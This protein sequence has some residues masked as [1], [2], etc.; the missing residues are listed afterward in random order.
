MD[1]AYPRCPVH[2][3]TDEPCTIH[4]ERTRRAFQQAARDLEQY[5]GGL[6]GRSS[7]QPVRLCR[8]GQHVME[9]ENLR[10]RSNGSREC[11]ACRRANQRKGHR[12]RADLGYHWISCS[13]HGCS[14]GLWRFGDEPY[15]CPTHR[16]EV[17]QAA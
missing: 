17:A 15:L 7:Q 9:G 12:A 11:R 8:S 6:Y 13:A 16:V 2:M 1:G 3:F 14:R 4:C 10:V 5:L